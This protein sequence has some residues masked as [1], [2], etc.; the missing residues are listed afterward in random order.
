MR[1][2]NLKQDSKINIV[3]ISSTSL[4]FI[5]VIRCIDW[6]VHERCLI[7]LPLHVIV[8]SDLVLKFKLHHQF[9]IRFK[10]R[11]AS[12]NKHVNNMQL[13]ATTSTTVFRCGCARRGP[14]A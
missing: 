13:K 2:T 12:S 3:C 10:V 9:I 4:Y 11:L 7:V 8:F 5:V 1:V 6:S 14:P